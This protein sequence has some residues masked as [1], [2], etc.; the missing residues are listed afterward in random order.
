MS[1]KRVFGSWL[2][3]Y[4]ER[5]IAL[6]RAGGACYASQER[7]LLAFDRHFDEEVPPQ[8]LSRDAVLHYLASLSCSPRAKDNVVSV[9]WQ[10]LSYSIRHGAPVEALAERPPKPPRYWRQRRPRLVSG[11]EVEALMVAAR[12]IPPVDILRPATMATLIGLLYA[13]GLRIGEALALDI[14]HLDRDD[15]L[16]TVVRGKFGKS[17]ALAV[18]E[19]TVEALVRYIE[20]PRRGVA[21]HG[22]APLFVSKQRRRL[23]QPTVWGALRAVCHKAQVSK[24]WP[25][26]HD[27]RHTFALHRVA[28]WYAEGKNVD[29]LLPVLS[30]YLGHSSVENTRVYLTNNGALLEQAAARFAD[31]TRVLDKVST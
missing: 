7:I 9:V 31:H 27:F 10:A 8:L 13:T 24:P 11:S 2:A 26:P 16:L 22:S 29:S 4:F 6:K 15:G 12:E 30:T 20:E 21:T 19:S 18:R 17:R 14:G 3:P 1:A 23:A 5:F 25:R 28:S